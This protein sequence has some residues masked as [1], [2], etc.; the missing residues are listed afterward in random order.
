M[1]SDETK[2]EKGKLSSLFYKTGHSLLKA[3]TQNPGNKSNSTINSYYATLASRIV[4]N[5]FSPFKCHN[6]N[7]TVT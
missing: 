1:N 7:K 4:E 2:W 3:T 5:Y 6:I